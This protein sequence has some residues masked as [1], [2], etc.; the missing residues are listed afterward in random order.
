MK[1][2]L[3]AIAVAALFVSA[4]AAQAQVQFGANAEFDVTKVSGSSLSNG[5]RVELNAGARGTSGDAFVEGKGTVLIKTD[6]DTAVDDAWIAAGTKA[7]DVKLGRFEATDLF[8]L[9]DTVLEQAGFVGYRANAL[10][11]R[12]DSKSAHA[13]LSIYAAQ[14]LKL[15]LGAI[16]SSTEGKSTGF[17]P[18]VS[19]SAGSLSFAA[20]LETV[21]VKGTSGSNTGVGVTGAYSLS[22]SAKVGLAFAKMDES[23]SIGMYGVFGSGKIGVIINDGAASTENA[24]TVYGSYTFPLLNVKG[25]SI[26]PAFSYSKPDSGDAVTALRVRL[27][28]DF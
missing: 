13:A 2:Q 10:R 19:Y 3:K 27:R 4:A 8:P 16:T 17:R 18:T 1:F 21:K 28:Y 22:D 7:F 12:V 26:T 24:T 20:G 15:E 5:G 14:G 9:Q 23:K 25:A 6:G 11:G